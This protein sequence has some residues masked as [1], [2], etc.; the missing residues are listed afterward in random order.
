MQKHV[1]LYVLDTLS[2]WEPGYAIAE[3]NSGR[4]FRTKKHVE[5]RRFLLPEGNIRPQKMKLLP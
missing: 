4:F 1:Y 3:L 2:D 5:N